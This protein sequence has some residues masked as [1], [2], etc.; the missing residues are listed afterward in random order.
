MQVR[1]RAQQG[2]SWECCGRK[3]PRLIVVCT[4]TADLAALAFQPLRLAF[5][6]S[7]G[8]I[9]DTPTGPFD[10]SGESLRT[11]TVLPEL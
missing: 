9:H 10:R 4:N 2:T 1:C 6:Y 5:G 3:G 11:L 7:S 8:S